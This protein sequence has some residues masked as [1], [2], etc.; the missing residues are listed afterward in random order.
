EVEIYVRLKED[1]L[2]GQAI[3]SLS[4]H[5]LDAVDVGTDRILAVGTDALFHSRRAE[6]GIL[7][8][9]RHDRDSDLRKYVGRHGADRRDAEK[10]NESCQHVERM[11]KSQR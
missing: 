1:F 6:P 3:Q 8:D 11:G 10:E 2:D 4:L 5:V 7:P 9:H